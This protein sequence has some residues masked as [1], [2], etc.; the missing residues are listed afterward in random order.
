MSEQLYKL[1]PHRDLQCYFL[2]PSAIAAI[3]GA[4]DTG[5]TISGTWRQQFDWAVVEWNRDNVFEH[6]SLR[7]LPDGDLSGL[8][9]TYQE[10]R[11]NCF[12][13][14][15]NLFPTVDWPNL[16]IWA[17]D[18]TGVEQV[19]YVPLQQYSTPVSG[20][21]QCAS[22]VMTVAGTPTAFDTVGICM[23]VPFTDSTGTYPEQHYYYQVGQGDQLSDV[24]A[25][26]AAVI[27]QQ[28]QGFTASS[29][30]ASI[31]LTWVGT[32]LNAG[33]TGSNG[34]RITVY[35]F[36]NAG[37]TEYWSTPTATLSGGQFPSTYQIALDFASL[38]GYTQDQSGNHFPVAAIPTKKVRKIRWTWAPDLQPGSFVRTE[39]SVA[40]TN[41]TV[42]GE[43]RAYFVAGLGS[44]RIEDDDPSVEYSANDWVTEGP[45]NYSGSRISVTS[46]QGATCTIAYTEAAPHQL[47]LGSRLL[48]P[49]PTVNI[50]I[51]GQQPLAF[52]LNVSG[53]DVLVRLPLGTLSA[54]T[55]TVVLTHMGPDSNCSLYFDFLEIAYPT[56]DLPDVPPQ[57]QL[58]LATDWDTYHSQSLPA[59]RTAWM[60]NKLGFTGRVNHYAGA[61][62]FYELVLTGHVY[63]S[64]TITF[65][66]NGTQNAGYAQLFVGPAGAMS[67]ITHLVLPDDTA[68]TVAQALA[69]LINQGFTAVWASASGKQLTIT[70]RAL[71]PWANQPDAPPELFVFASFGGNSN[72]TAS[73]NATI[74]LAGGVPGAPYDGSLNS[75]WTPVTYY[76]R[77]DMT[78][79]PAINRAARDWS[80]A[81]FT[82]LGGYA[83]DVVAAFS[84]ELKN[85]D[86]NTAAGLAQCR[87]DGTPVIVN[88][89]A[90]MTNFSPAVI[91]FWKRVYLDMA[92]L[93]AEA[94][95]TPYLQSGEV[96]WWYYPWN[97]QGEQ[98]VSM[99]FYDAYTQGQFRA[100]YGTDMQV[101]TSNTADPRQ[102]PNEAAFLPAV[103]GAATAEIRSAL[104]A[105]FPGARYEV[106]YPVDTND[107][108]LNK[109]VNF[110]KS[111]WIP[112]N[113][114]CLKTESFTFT[115]S[116]NL[117]QSIYS[118]SVSAA[119]GFP[120]SQRSHLVGIG[121]SHTVW[122]KE[123]N[124][125]QSEGM[126]SVVLFALDQYC[127]IGYPPPPFGQLGR[128]GR[129]G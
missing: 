102:Y 73:T 40:V 16:R 96:Q 31:V 126:E 34:N 13:V 55:H 124:I 120:N 64:A 21:Y 78:A 61:L 99:P 23:P 48:A 69:N 18:S 26:L 65:N 54:G 71:T 14:E 39:F 119:E 3:S 12:P 20:T 67:T 77:T 38:S 127:L 115:G 49:G 107:T 41:W 44:R 122:Q 45:G 8:K 58:A 112:A 103:I 79:I 85:A 81:Y 87:S 95:L 101:V 25:K 59:E 17:A 19:Y 60:I 56:A 6:P 82:A 91:D 50:S 11:T 83:T 129:Q 37:A 118:M 29:N 51:D 100:K 28:S 117:D 128:T 105:Q 86:P 36:A 1:S 33:K 98:P 43:N 116:S 121:D 22:A 10:T 106:L 47:F 4:S 80:R 62:W 2:T 109:L 74:P 104:Q 75:T 15:S 93:Q 27:N 66:Q 5:F 123:V 94:G 76:W 32:G 84:T 89:P 72:F 92:N 46:R 90:V 53:E 57:P 108:P 113:L 7:Y 70:Q 42:T 88:T 35:G 30:G 110:P 9:L 111:D 97:V 52:N 63:N 125:A 114:T 68:A 24:A